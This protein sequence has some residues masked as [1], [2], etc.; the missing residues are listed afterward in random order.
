[1]ERRARGDRKLVRALP[2]Q[3]VAD[4]EADP[5]VEIEQAREMARNVAELGCQIDA[6]DVASETGG[7]V[8]RRPADA[9]ADVEN[10]I[11]R[12]RL[13]QSGNVQRRLQAAAM[14]LIVGGQLL[15]ARAIGIDALVQQRRVQAGEEIAAGVVREDFAAHQTGP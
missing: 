6:C 15:D 7:D 8:A 9:T 5:V 4:L 12:A 11:G 14:E 2:A 3:G 13:H 1:M 10:V